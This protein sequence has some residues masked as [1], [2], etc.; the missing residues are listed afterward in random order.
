LVVA[1]AAL[2]L[3]SPTAFVQSRQLPDGGF[4]EQGRTAS[5]ELTAWAVL[6]LRAAGVATPK[7]HDYLV[8]HEG[9]LTTTTDVEL[10]IAAEAVSGG[11]SP[12]LLARVRAAERASGAIGPLLNW[13]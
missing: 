8:A 13:T 3:V 11:A 7:A 1:A 10:A 2:S 4:A 12:G 5:P 6:G 9:D